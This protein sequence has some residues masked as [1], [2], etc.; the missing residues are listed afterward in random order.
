[1]PRQNEQVNEIWI[2]DKGR[3]GHHHTRAENRLKTPMVRGK[4]GTWT[5]VDWQTAYKH[6][7]AKL[8]NYGDRVG[9]LAGPSLS[10]EDYWEIRRTA[11]L[12]SSN[13]RL[14]MW[15]A[16]MTGAEAIA[17]VGV[18][19][20]TRIQDMGS[21]SAILVIASDFEE[22]APVWW[23]Q[24]KQAADRGV[25]VIVAN[26]RST[27]LDN[28]AQA[29]IHYDYPQAVSVL[30]G[31][32][33]HVLNAGKAPKGEGVSKLKALFKKAPT[34]YP[35]VA[36]ILLNAQNLII[37][38]GSEGL[39]LSEHRELM[40][41][42]ANLL[43]VSGHAGRPNNGL[44]AVWQGANLQ[45]AADMGF[46]SEA[47]LSLFDTPPAMWVISGADVVTEDIRAAQAIEQAEYVVATSQ[48][49]TPTTERADIVLPIQS[50]AE[51]EGSFTN[52]M[53]RVQRFYVLQGI[54]GDS[55]PDWKIFGHIAAQLGGEK[56]HISA[57]AVMQDIT[58]KV[59]RYAEMSYT[60]LSKIEDQFPDV[61]GD[62]LYFGGTSYSNRGGLGVQWAADAEK[63]TAH[64]S[65]RP[66][67][68][69]EPAKKGE[70]LV[71][72]PTQVLYDHDSAV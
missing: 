19:R 29:V 6:I 28:Y 59:P 68:V 31:F 60:N 12:V 10:N 33:G 17:Q 67:T 3:W 45:G 55:L 64:L 26:G 2:C 46:S 58:R 35:D 72:V 24:V 48:F 42:A 37:F 21:E 61:G 50:F 40:Q 62:D 49:M 25:K 23:L 11:E 44:V 53:R 71:V 56:P 27:K 32:T 39:T 43:I 65:V 13:P 18:G 34:P 66:V 51:R 5:P 54:I 8:K 57:A 69:S 70:H 9:F 30:N 47:T 52:G 7:A 4:D 16:T 14:G 1:M 20:G 22:E 38:V 15:P 41:A 36:D 63:S